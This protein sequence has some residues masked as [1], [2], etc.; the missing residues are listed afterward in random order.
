[1]INVGTSTH[2]MQVQF[3]WINHSIAISTSVTFLEMKMKISEK[4]LQI[5]MVVIPQL[6]ILVNNNN[7]LNHLKYGFEKL[8][9]LVSEIVHQQSE[10]LKEVEL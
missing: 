5:F 8:M 9:T 2:W 1:M 7:D 4:Q 3:L 10:E 6:A